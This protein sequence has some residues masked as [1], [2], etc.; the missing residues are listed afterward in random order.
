MARSVEALQ[1]PLR[2]VP[3]VLNAIDMVTAFRHERRAVIDALVM[4]LRD[5][6][7]IVHL[8]AI[9]VDD[10]VRCHFLSNDG[11][12]VLALASG[13]IAVYTVLP[14][15]NNPKTGTFPATPRLFLPLRTRP[16]SSH[17]LQSRRT[18]ENFL[19]LTGN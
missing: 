3:K 1:M 10:A 7:H 2:L 4:E 18:E 16:N 11:D 6:Q 5:I 12:Q 19:A 9:G 8:K 14:R 13:M 17:R 15:V